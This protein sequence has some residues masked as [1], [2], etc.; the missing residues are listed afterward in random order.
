[1]WLVRVFVQE[2]GALRRLEN[3]PVGGQAAGGSA[4]LRIRHVVVK[5]ALDILGFF[6]IRFDQSGVLQLF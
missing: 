6:G 4:A 3:P 5:Y 1:M 2:G